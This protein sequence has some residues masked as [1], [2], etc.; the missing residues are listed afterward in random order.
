[1]PDTFAPLQK[2]FSKNSKRSTWF[3]D[4]ISDEIKLKNQA[5]AKQK[6]DRS[7]DPD[8]KLVLRKLKNNVKATIH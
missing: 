1:V 5:I 7:G 3:S 8:D 6:S 2:V 4:V